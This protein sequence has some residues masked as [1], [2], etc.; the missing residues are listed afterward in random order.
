MSENDNN[1]M[2]QWKQ[3]VLKKNMDEEREKN[4]NDLYSRGEIDARSWASGMLELKYR[5]TSDEYIFA[6]CQRQKEIEIQEKKQ[7]EHIKKIERDYRLSKKAGVLLGLA[8][9]FGVFLICINVFVYNVTTTETY[10]EPK[11][12]DT[13]VCYVSQYGECYH[14]KRCGYI[15][16]SY[17]VREVT[18]YEAEKAGYRQ[19]SA[20]DR[21]S[22]TTITIQEEHKREVQSEE[23]DY[24]KSAIISAVC[25]VVVFVIFSHIMSKEY[26]EYMKE[27]RQCQEKK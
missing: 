5:K 7:Q 25:G 22:R 23:V 1:V 4:L 12:I 20:C 2:H 13:Y 6:E 26:K 11:E 19:C 14:E 15:K 16:Y 8:M 24:K 21:F 17:G 3:Y 27:E 10:Y 9:A 18:I